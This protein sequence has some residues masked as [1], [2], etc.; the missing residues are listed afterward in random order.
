MYFSSE[1]NV[2][3]YAPV[4][5]NFTVFNKNYN[6]NS[7]FY[8]NEVSDCNWEYLYY[9]DVS[10][11]NPLKRAGWSSSL[12]YE[13]VQSYLFCEDEITNDIMSAYLVNASKF[14]GVRKVVYDNFLTALAYQW[15]ADK[16]ANE[17][18]DE[19]HVGWAK[20]GYP[21][22]SSFT[23]VNGRFISVI[24]TTCAVS[25]LDF[26][27]FNRMYGLYGSLLEEYVMSLTGSE[28]TC[29]VSEVFKGLLNGG[30]FYY[31]YDSEN[32]CTVL[33][34]ADNSSWLEFSDWGYINSLINRVDLQNKYNGGMC[35][36]NF[37]YSDDSDILDN[38]FNLDFFKPII[39]CLND[40]VEKL[41]SNPIINYSIHFVAGLGGAELIQVGVI[42]ALAA[43]FSNP[44]GL[45][46]G[47]DIYCYGCF[48][49]II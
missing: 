43:T 13:S 15:L 5:T 46:I 1:K 3:S 29:A 24:Y 4:Y 17:L 40:L 9:G 25:G 33:K 27:R 35:L 10:Y 39:S 14:S 7:I 8:N 6:V 49:N 20:I 42:I 28:A 48:R 21:L 23:G 26:N 41:S 18:A 22:V 47:G 12:G 30:E 38:L 45:I 36:G 31:Y 34:L 37:N 2:N 16:L 32:L 44:V 19:C 11:D